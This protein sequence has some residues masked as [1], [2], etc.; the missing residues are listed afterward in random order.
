MMKRIF[1]V[2]AVVLVFS[3]S[4]LGQVTLSYSVNDDPA[5]GFKSYTVQATGVGINVLGGFN[6]IGQVYQVWWPDGSQTEW[7]GNGT[8]TGNPMDSYVVF[9]DG[10]FP[11]ASNFGMSGPMG[12]TYTCETIGGSGTQGLGTLNNLSGGSFGAGSIEQNEPAG[13]IPQLPGDANSDGVVDTIDACVVASHWNQEVM[14][15]CVEGDFNGDGTVNPADASILAAHWNNIEGMGDLDD[16]GIDL[17]YPQ[18]EEYGALGVA[19]AYLALGTPSGNL[20]TVDLM[21]LVLPENTSV[22]VELELYTAQ[23]DSGGFYTDI[24]CYEF[25]GAGA[26]CVGV[27]EPSMLII[28]VTG[29][30]GLVLMRR[31]G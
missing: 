11:D 29:L 18:I 4:A 19:D 23:Y 13:G 14:G 27:P 3:S 28:M 26:L 2:L 10:R 25:S 21:K 22:D 6:V 30:A 16:Q 7:L 17:N 12:P 9:G 5:E 8:A 20:Q 24:D 15:G 1:F 31:R